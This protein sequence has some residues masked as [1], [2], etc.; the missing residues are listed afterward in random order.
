M[1]RP[2][3][4]E[5]INDYLK[6]GVRDGHRHLTADATEEDRRKITSTNAAKMFRFNLD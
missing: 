3:I 2:P 1:V 6:P 4:R 5:D